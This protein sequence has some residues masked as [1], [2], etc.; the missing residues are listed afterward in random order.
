MCETKRLND[1][2]CGCRY[3]V[4]EVCLLLEQLGFQD[5]GPF[6]EAG[7]TGADLADLTEEEMRTEL[8]LSNLQV[9]PLPSLAV[10][11]PASCITSSFLLK[12]R[13]KNWGSGNLLACAKVQ[14]H[15]DQK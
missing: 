1:R 5:T 15:H 13:E 6:R 3:R 14:A 12:V 10:E 7:V 9:P 8:R 4:G 2:E 11:T